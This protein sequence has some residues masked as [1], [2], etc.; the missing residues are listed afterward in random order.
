MRSIE[1]EF[2]RRPHLYKRGWIGRWMNIEDVRRRRMEVNESREV[3]EHIT[4]L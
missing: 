4:R 1:D 2:R 3:E